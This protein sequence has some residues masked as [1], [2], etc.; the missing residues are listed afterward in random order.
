MNTKELLCTIGRDEYK[1]SVLAEIIDELLEEC[2]E[3]GKYKHSF[4]L[5]AHGPHH[6][7]ETLKE[8]GLH[9]KYTYPEIQRVMMSSGIECPE[10]VSKEDV[11]YAVNS[12]YKTYYPLIP[13]LS[14]AVKFADKYLKEDY[15]VKN[16]RAFME[17][18][19]KC[20]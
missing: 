14:H 18:K 12:L 20:V 11:V 15:P 3:P 13:D 17:W 6:T 10:G 7:E 9:I 2:A 19:N 4:H 1:I 16:G 5:L 8:S